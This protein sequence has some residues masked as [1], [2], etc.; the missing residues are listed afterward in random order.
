MIDLLYFDTRWI[1]AW[2]KARRYAYVPHLI[3]NLGLSTDFLSRHHPV[4]LEIDLDVKGENVF[5][6]L[7]FENGISQEWTYVCIILT[8]SM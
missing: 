7:T 2:N 1:H 8:A 4:L 5:F 6:S 3:R